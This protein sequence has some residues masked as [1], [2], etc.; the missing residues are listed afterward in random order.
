M[1]KSRRLKGTTAYDYDY[2]VLGHSLDTEILKTVEQ[3]ESLNDS[4]SFSE[5]SNSYHIDLL[6]QEKLSLETALSLISEDLK[7]TQI[8]VK[9]LTDKIL[10]LEHEN[11]KLKN[12]LDNANHVSEKVISENIFTSLNND[13]NPI[14]LDSDGSDSC[15][16]PWQVKTRRRRKTKSTPME[17]ESRTMKHVKPPSRPAV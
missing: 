4:I 15:S 3:H 10:L 7:S 12:A 5:D 17:S 9:T 11:T 8:C 13:P 16:E 1:Q 2:D 6:I 14:Y